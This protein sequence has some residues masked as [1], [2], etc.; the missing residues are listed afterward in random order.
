MYVR[1]QFLHLPLNPVIFFNLLSS[2]TAGRDKSEEQRKGDARSAPFISE[3]ML[4][5]KEKMLNIKGNEGMER[6]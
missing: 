6:K 1:S 4:N 2:E 5:I 3:E